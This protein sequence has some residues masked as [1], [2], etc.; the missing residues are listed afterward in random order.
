MK[1]CRSRIGSVW[2][3]SCELQ[4]F[5][6]SLPTHIM[7]KDSRD[8]DFLVAFYFFKKCYGISKRDLSMDEV[9]SGPQERFRPL[10]NFLINRFYPCNFRF[11]TQ[12]SKTPS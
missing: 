1:P 8:N 9:S 2:T 7:E 4:M 11:S 10:K 3:E 6:N 12:N 5:G